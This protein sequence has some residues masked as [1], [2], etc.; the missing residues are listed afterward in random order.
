MVQ[1]IS[2]IFLFMIIVILFWIFLLCILLLAPYR[3]RLYMDF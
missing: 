3:Q 1:L 2:G